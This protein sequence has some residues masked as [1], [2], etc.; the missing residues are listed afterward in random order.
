MSVQE[1]LTQVR[2]VD[3]EIGILRR[4]MFDT[5]MQAVRTTPSLDGV[6]VQHSADVHR[7]DGIAELDEAIYNRIRDLAAMKAQAVRLI[8]LL[9]DPRHRQLLTAYYVDCHT[10]DGRRKTWEMV[11]VELNLSWRQLM[12]ARKLA[13]AGVEKFCDRIAQRNC[14][15][16]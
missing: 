3:E 11:A 12:Y 14:D 8:A 4:S 13:L 5:W 10:R 15:T 9:P 2:A 7:F 1:W 6:A 16:V